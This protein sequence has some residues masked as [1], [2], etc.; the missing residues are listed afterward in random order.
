M[1]QAAFFIPNK[2]LFGGYPTR[3]QIKDLKQAG[4]TW[5][6][7]LTHWSDTRIVPYNE[8]VDRWL[9]YPIE[10]ESVPQSPKK[11]LIFLSMIRIILNRLETNE[12][13]Y[14]HCR[15]GH[16]RSV[17]VVSCILSLMNNTTARAGIFAAG[18]FH[19][20]RPEL[21]SRWR[22]GKFPLSS[23]QIEFIENFFGQLYMYSNFV[24]DANIT[25]GSPEFFRHLLELQYYLNKDK[26]ALDTL[27]N[28]GCKTI[29]GEG[30]ISVA[31]QH[32][33]HYLLHQKAAQ[34]LKDTAHIR[35][36]F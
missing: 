5:F 34:I 27:L 31:L 15:G 17:L 25:A 22:N 35:L 2:A 16:G 21:S 32:L 3:K 33:R 11:F 1:N 36:T 13:I 7:D 24:S 6:I 18:T 4:V 14:L 30:H 12:K 23:A 28:S 8:L 26:V 9:N 20:A 19:L 10:D 29:M